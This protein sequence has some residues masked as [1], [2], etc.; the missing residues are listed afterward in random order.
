MDDAAGPSNSASRARSSS[1]SCGCSDGTPARLAPPTPQRKHEH[2]RRRA[3]ARA[4]GASQ[5][6]RGVPAEPRLEQHELAVARDQEIEHLA[7]AVAGLQP[8]AHQEPQVARQRRIGIVDRLVLADHAAQFARQMRAPAPRAPDRPGFRRAAPPAPGAISAAT[9]ARNRQ[10][11]ASPPSARVTPPA[12]SPA[13]FCAGLGAP[14]RSRRSDS[15]SSAAEHHHHRAEPDQQHQR[16]VIEPHRDRAVGIGIAERQI[17]LARRR[18]SASAASVVGSAAPGR[19]AWTAPCA[20]T[21]S[22]SR[23]TVK[24]AVSSR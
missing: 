19:C 11:F 20:P 5:S 13:C 2:E 6:S 17:E 3:P 16:L 10:R 23:R 22:P 1:L 14:T 4:A 9:T 7:V 15:D 18:A 24:L 8:L 12:A 21:T